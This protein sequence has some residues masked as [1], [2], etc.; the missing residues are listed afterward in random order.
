MD[1]YIDEITTVEEF[2]SQNPEFAEVAEI[3]KNYLK[4]DYYYN[5]DEEDFIII[6]VE[7]YKCV[8]VIVDNYLPYTIG[9]TIKPFDIER[10]YPCQELVT[11]FAFR[12]Y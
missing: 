6:E 4:N 12:R 1:N 11:K 9:E 3:A 5:A 2:I 7:G 8:A 10:T